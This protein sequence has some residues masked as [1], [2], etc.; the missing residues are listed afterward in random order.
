MHPAAQLLRRVG[1]PLGWRRGSNRLRLHH[2]RRRGL[3]CFLRG[4]TRRE[5]R[6]LFGRQVLRL[7]VDRF[8][9]RAVKGDAS[10]MGKHRQAR[11]RP[12]DATT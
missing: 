6:Q 12:P 8:R 11:T 4:L 3:S 5:L 9:R 1:R 2:G 10:V 7:G